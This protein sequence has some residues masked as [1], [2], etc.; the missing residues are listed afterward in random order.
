MLDMRST[1]YLMPKPIDIPY[2]ADRPARIINRFMSFSKYN[3]IV[4]GK[5]KM[6]MDGY[7]E[8]GSL[9]EAMDVFEVADKLLMENSKNRSS[10]TNQLTGPLRK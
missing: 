5:I 4:I 7:R 1:E 2:K 3:R 8:H 9:S 6:V 10:Q